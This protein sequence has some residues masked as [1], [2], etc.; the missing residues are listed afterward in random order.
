MLLLTV[1]LLNITWLLSPNMSSDFYCLL[2]IVGN[3]SWEFGL[4]YLPN[5][6][7]ICSISLILMDF[8]DPVVTWFRHRRADLVLFALSPS[9]F[10]GLK[11]TFKILTAI[12]TGFNR[13]QHFE[14]LHFQ[15]ALSLL[16]SVLPLVFQTFVFSVYSQGHQGNFCVYFRES[17]YGV[18]TFIMSYLQNLLFLAALVSN[19]YFTHAAI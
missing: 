1:H 18:S 13:L 6:V 2:N 7:D 8:L 15:L 4:C 19:L 14:T 11:W 9:A 16:L 17:L 5:S 10:Q 3:T 12:F